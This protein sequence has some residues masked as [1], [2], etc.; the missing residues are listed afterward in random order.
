[1][2][3]DGKSSQV[4]PVN[5]EVPEG[6]PFLVQHFSYYTLM[7][8]LRMLSVL[9]LSTLMILLSTLSVIR[10]LICG[11][12]QNWLLNLN[13]TYETLWTGAGSGF[14]FYWSNNT[15][16]IDV[17]KDGSVLEVKSSFKMVGL[18]LFSKLDWKSASKEI[19]TLNSFYE[20]LFS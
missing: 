3:L 8:F 17:K 11:K 19:G 9:L 1:M 16:A 12:N 2:V 6:F 18:T 14:L 20:V 15:G 7:T 4:Y 5:A 10:H 13:L